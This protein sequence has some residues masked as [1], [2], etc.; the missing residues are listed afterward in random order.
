MAEPYGGLFGPSGASGYTPGP[1]DWLAPASGG[2][3]P[4]LGLI[5]SINPSFLNPTAYAYNAPYDPTNTQTTSSPF[6]FNLSQIGGPG[7][8]AAS[9]SLF[10][11][12]FGG[13]GGDRKSV[14]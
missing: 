2:G 14:V 1:M 9:S 4:S 6:S 7:G 12:L 5:G 3:P 13:G 11:G 8:A 10:G